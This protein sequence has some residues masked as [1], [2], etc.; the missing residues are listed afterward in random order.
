MTNI[1]KSCLIIILIIGM[2][3][4]IYTVFLQPVILTWGASEDELTMPLA[5]DSLA[6]YISSTRAISINAPIAEVWNWAIQLGADRGGFFSYS[7]IEKSLGYKGRDVDTIKPEFLEMKLGRIIPGSL[8]ES[9][10]VIKYS[11]PVLAVE[12]GKSFVL[13]NWGA[14]VVTK[15]NS[16]Q[17]RLI[18]RTHGRE[19]PNLRIMISNFFMV[20]LHHIMER[21][22]LMG[23]K[24]Q[25]ETGEPQSSTSDNLW[26]VGVI[27]STFA[28]ILLVFISRGV[29]R[30]LLTAIYGII[31]LWPL[32]IFDPQPIYSIALLVI[33]ASTITWFL[34]PKKNILGAGGMLF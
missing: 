18:V 16:N 14:F 7:F 31:W 15:V 34:L 20:P 29:Q 28:I 30:V 12:P 27:L 26:I 11:W 6:P 5:G 8:D 23:F 3:M 32:L 10:S 17:T 1:K 13:K 24:A 25:A 9:K 21:R 4:F 33:I 22:M 2:Q 19:T